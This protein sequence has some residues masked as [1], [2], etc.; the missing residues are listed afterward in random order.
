MAD[1]QDADLRVPAGVPGTL[2]LGAAVA[3]ITRPLLWIMSL[4]TMGAVLGGVDVLLL[5]AGIG[6]PV[7][8]FVEGLILVV[9]AAAAVAG[10]V[11]VR[12]GN[13]ATVRVIERL[14]L[15]YLIGT[16]FYMV[17]VLLW[18]ILF[19]VEGGFS[20]APF[21]FMILPLATNAYLLVLAQRVI[22][23]CRDTLSP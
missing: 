8:V 7:L 20:I 13:P 22:R 14:G 16:A 12:S 3:I 9:S 10:A 17:T 23:A 1:D 11:A 6:L 19:L 2:A 5:K 15:A 21:L 18:V 4:G